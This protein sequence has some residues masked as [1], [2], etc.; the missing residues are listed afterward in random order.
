MQKAREKEEEKVEDE[1]EED[2]YD[3]AKFDDSINRDV[4]DSPPSSKSPPPGGYAVVTRHSDN[5]PARGT[6]NYSE[7]RQVG[8]ASR[9]RSSTDPVEL[10]PPPPPLHSGISRTYTEGGAQPPLPL[11]PRNFNVKHGGNDDEDKDGM[12]DS[13]ENLKKPQK[14]Y[15]SLD[16]EDDNE[17]YE[18]VPEDIKEEILSSSA[19]SRNPRYHDNAPSPSSPSPTK[20]PRIVAVGT[21]D[22]P[23][24]K[25]R[26]GRQRPESTSDEAEKGGHNR[27]SFFNRI[28]SSSTSATVGGGGGG[29]GGGKREVRKGPGEGGSHLD[30]PHPPSLPPLPPQPNQLDDEDDEDDTYDSVRPTL[31]SPK[32]A[33]LPATKSTSIFSSRVKEPLPEVPEDSG[34]G[35]AAIVVERER[36]R[37]KG[38][39]DYDT[40]RKEEEEEG[41]KG[42]PDYDTVKRSG[43][44]NYAK[45]TSHGDGGGP[46]SHDSE[47]YARVDPQI[48]ERKRAFSQSKMKEEEGEEEGEEEEEDPYDRVKDLEPGYTSVKELLSNEAT[49]DTP[50]QSEPPPTQ[51]ESSTVGADSA[52]ADSEVASPTHS[53]TDPEMAYAIIDPKI[54]ERKRAESM[55][56]KNSN[57]AGSKNSNTLPVDTRSESTSPVPPIPPVGDLG[58]ISEF[59]PPPI[60][61][62]SL[63]GD[64]LLSPSQSDT[65]DPYSKV[66]AATKT[67]TP[68]A[69][70]DS[71]GGDA[72]EK[73][74]VSKKEEMGAETSTLVI[75]DSVL[76]SESSEGG[77]PVYDSLEPQTPLY[78]S[79]D[80]TQPSLPPS[81]PSLSPPSSSNQQQPTYD[82]L[83]PD[84]KGDSSVNNNI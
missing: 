5:S 80:P 18:S 33:T 21:P 7:V 66:G 78:D 3:Y 23:K 54:V 4:V 52:V 17:M 44:H 46:V 42:E 71:A 28:R 79:L 69:A 68:N 25:S 10:P 82:S 70:G 62:Q 47:G 24:S 19:P 50:T 55:G 13:I 57:A 11:P 61:E 75:R 2:P 76:S 15:D 49:S 29:G 36:I 51:S 72:K 58:D 56:S 53:L 48:V 67:D 16:K 14:L 65:E 43:T 27:L 6:T 74:G 34:S 59:D 31:T 45:V 8:G 64:D 41:E 30:L 39:P 9:G 38:D 22:S 63:D 83:L 12:Y 20:V 32:S 40:V 26:K 1:E 84:G 77:V 35:S 81:Q 60:P 73:V 37:D